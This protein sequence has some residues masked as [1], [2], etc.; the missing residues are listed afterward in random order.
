MLGSLLLACA[1]LQSSSATPQAST[2][3]APSAQVTPAK[4]DADTDTSELLKVKRIF[5]DSFGDDLISKEM[6]SMIVSS[7]V[8]TK[9]F[10]VTENRDKADAVLKGVALEKTAQELHAYGE[11]TAVGGASGGSH[12]EISGSVVNGNGTISGSSSGGF[13]ARH[14]G[15]SDSSVNTETIDNARVAIRLVNR[16]GDVIWT[17]TQESKGAKYKGASA[18]VAEKCVKQLLHDVEKLERADAPKATP[19]ATTP[20]AD[21]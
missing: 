20:N 16:D 15:T 1:I 13:I 4:P 6:Q 11:S 14:M 19:V 2:P 3:P 8:E 21:H 5:V 10:K 18:D 7:L 12:G 9:R 17:S